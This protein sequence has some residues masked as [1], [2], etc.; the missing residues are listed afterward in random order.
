[1]MGALFVGLGVALYL[2]SAIANLAA[3]P[4]GL[5]HFEMIAGAGHYPHVQFPSQV[6]ALVLSV[7]DS[8]RA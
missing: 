4:P 3:L 8:V 1:M 2:G 7:L 6:A 5:G